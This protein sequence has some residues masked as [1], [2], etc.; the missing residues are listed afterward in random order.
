M[1]ATGTRL[2][3]FE[4]GSML[5]AGGM[6]EVYRARDVR[7]GRDVA[8]KVLPS[9]LG[10]DPERGARLQREARLLA[11]LNHPNIAAIYGIEEHEGRWALVLELVEGETLAA[12]V[13]RGPIPPSEVIVL[14]RQMIDALDAAH[15]RG[16]VHRDLKPANITLTRDGTIKILDFGIAK[17]IEAPDTNR[18][19]GTAATVTA[20]TQGGTVLGTP[21]YMS[22]EQAR[23]LAVDKRADIWAFGCVLFELLT[24]RRPFDGDSTSDVLVSVLDREPPWS[25]LPD[26]TP[27]ALRRLIERCLEKDPRARLRDIGDARAELDRAD[28]LAGARPGRAGRR[29]PVLAAAVAVAAAAT[30]AL[31]LWAWTRPAVPPAFPRVTRIVATAAHEFAPALSPDGKWIAY[32]SD[33]RGRTDVWVKFIAGGEPANLTATLDLDLQTLDYVGGVQISPDGSQIAVAAARHGAGPRDYSTWVIPAPLGGAPRRVLEP[34]TQGLTWS[35]DGKQIAY[36]GVGGS[37]GDTVWV[38]DHDGQNARL[39]VPA[40]GGFHMHWLR[41][42]H[43]SRYVYFSYGA[44]SF[45]SEPM[46]IYRVPAAGG[47][48]QA[49]IPTSRRAV[50]PFLDAAGRGLLY[51]ANPDTVEMGL[52][53]RDLPS[54]RDYPLINGVGEY[55][56]PSLSADGTR[57]V[58]MVGTTQHYLARLPIGDGASPALERLTDPLSGDGDPSFSPDGTRVAF[59]SLR[60]GERN[61]WIA[62][63]D[64]TNPVPLTFGPSLDERPAFAP[65]GREI[66][67]VS[68]RGGRRGIWVVNMDGR[69]PRLVATI[70]VRDRLT[71]SRDGRSIVCSVSTGARPTLAMVSRDSGQVRMLPVAGAATSPAWSTREDVIAYL[72][73]RTSGPGA[74]VRFI[75]PDGT[76]AP[77]PMPPEAVNFPGN[78]EIAWAPD[79]R[80]FVKAAVPGTTPASIWIIDT[81][82][83]GASRQLAQLPPATQLRGL[84]FTPDGSALLIGVVTRTGD[85]VLAE[86]RR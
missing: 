20:G 61:I 53:W 43:D 69:P 57:M 49:V 45:N 62:A 79:G 40:H 74:D 18:E 56:S 65:D 58:A 73:A 82:R 16:I 51:S 26:S 31:L 32:L 3:S 76:P 8:I 29:G 83:P 37:A 13:S 66:A 41:W 4:I 68:D 55:S 35:P 63:R 28:G 72:E 77:F 12:R 11:S 36:M 46:E 60:G 71:W 42:S 75:H 1:L 19:P 14:A 24:G 44:Q 34:G 81:T 23:G 21:A 39:L 80:R 78:L 38:A 27:A 85:I 22:P 86:R 7:L 59:S 30:A 84:A 10:V 52:W 17:A 54:G 64:F 50:F 25:A 47:P 15:E 48:I 33:A 6:G 2:G 5:G 67:F 70:A 9:L